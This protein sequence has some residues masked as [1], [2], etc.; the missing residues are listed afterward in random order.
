MRTLLCFLLALCLPLFAAAEA[1]VQPVGSLLTHCA[2]DAVA[3]LDCAALPNG[4]T[5]LNVQFLADLEGKGKGDWTHLRLILLGP[6]DASSWQITYS[7]TLGDPPYDKITW[8]I[9]ASSV[10][11]M[12]FSGLIGNDVCQQT[13]IL[14]DLETGKQI[15]GPYTFEVDADDVPT[16]TY[17]GDFRIE[18]YFGD[19]SEAVTRTIITY[20]PTGVSAEYMLD[21][22]RTWHAFGEA[23]VSFRS[24]MQD[25]GLC[26]VYNA[27]CEP[28]GQEIPLPATCAD[29]VVGHSALQGDT[30]F[31][32]VWSN[33][34]DPDHRTYTVF[35]MTEDLQ[36]GD[37]VAS[38]TLEEGHT[39]GATVACGDGFLLTLQRPW[40][41]DTD[42]FSQLAYLSPQGELVILDSEFVSQNDLVTLLPA[43]DANHAWV[44]LRDPQN[45]GWSRWEYAAGESY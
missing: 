9:G 5:L 19:Y 36:I 37:A 15:G 31:L 11:V 7:R 43:E 2:G 12:L 45:R 33:R 40:G 30:L 3:I 18:E 39:L 24:S 20:M 44:I 42:T 1:P 34:E 27:N 21:G 22:Q 17:S 26:W 29:P 41:W 14:F 32:F 28:A 6:D 16:I 38:F 25:G 10:K 23:L 8:A 13:D 4:C 35:P